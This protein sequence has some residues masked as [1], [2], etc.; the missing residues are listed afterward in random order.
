MPN[1]GKS[2]LLSVLTNAHPLI[3]DYPFTT[4]T[5]NLGLLRL[6]ER[7]VILADIPGIIEGASQGK[8]LGLS[9][10]RHIERCAALLYPRGS[11]GG[12]VPGNGARASRGA[13]V[14]LRRSFR[15]GRGSSW[16]PS[17]TCPR[18]HRVWR[19]LQAAFPEDRILAISSFS[20]EGVNEL[21]KAI[22]SLVG[23]A[24]VIA[25]GDRAEETGD[26]GR[27]P[28]RHVQ[29]RALRPSLRR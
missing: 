7:D 24:G 3:A 25:G 8:G 1:A 29:S 13:R 28:G 9:F 19:D 26:E 27:R 20:R 17:S 5:P 14:L 10:L 21:K 12:A 18:P 2:T 22:L 4:H 15:P 16:E 11:L 23:A 6:P